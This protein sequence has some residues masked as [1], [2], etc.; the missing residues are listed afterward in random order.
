MLA[1]ICRPTIGAVTMVASAH[2]EFFGSLDGVQAEKSALVRAIPA[3]GAVV[4]NADD[5]R[6]IAMRPLTA[7]RV[8]TVSASDPRADVCAIGAAGETEEGLRVTLEIAGARREVRLRFAGRH[9]VGN[10]LAAAGV[11]LALGLPPDDI[12]RGLEAARPVKGRC[13]WKRAGSVRILDDTYNANPTSLRA[14][15]DTLL[16]TREAGRRVVVLGDMLELGDLA[17]AAHREAGRAVA[18]AGASEFIGV[19]PLSRLAVEA[20][21]EA[22]LAE[23]H[24]A[25]TFEDT[26]ALLLKRLAPGD[27]LLVKGSRGMRMERVVDALVARLGGED[28]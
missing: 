22:G 16:A 17:E 13:V 20:A 10:A 15:L 25:A 27:V 3:E 18:A 19:G 26:V 2:T 1:A 21:R 8:L 14:A 24:H 12:A 23:S 11:G 9:N 7:A 5:T 6:V 4:L 28:G